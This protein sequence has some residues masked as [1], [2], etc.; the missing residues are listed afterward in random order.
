MSTEEKVARW[1]FETSF[2]DP[3]DESWEGMM[4][5]DLI[6]EVRKILEEK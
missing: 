4:L 3:E 2:L 1:I 6:K 5:E